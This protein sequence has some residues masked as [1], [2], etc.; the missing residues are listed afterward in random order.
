VGLLVTESFNKAA[1]EFGEQRL[2]ESL[3]RHCDLS[4][5]ALLAS[6]VEDVLSFSAHEQHDDITLIVATCKKDQ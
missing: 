4:S 5:E 6:I 2:I 3:R 1:D